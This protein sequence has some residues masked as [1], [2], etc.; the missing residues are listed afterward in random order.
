[1]KCPKI[2][3]S[4]AGLSLNVIPLSNVH[5]E[6]N[7]RRYTKVKRAQLVLEKNLFQL[8]PVF[9]RSIQEVGTSRYRPPSHP[10]YVESLSIE[11]NIILCD[12]VR[13][14]T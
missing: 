3:F 9:Q 4:N 7:L 5:F 2:A 1:L 6:F 8:N 14:T 13:Q 10:T 11:L 12:K